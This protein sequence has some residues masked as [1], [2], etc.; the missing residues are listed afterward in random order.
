[1]RAIIHYFYHE[2]IIKIRWRFVFSLPAMRRILPG[3]LD[4]PMK[5]LKE[6]FPKPS[7]IRHFISE[8][9]LSLVSPPGIGNTPVADTSTRQGADSPY[10]F[11]LPLPDTSLLPDIILDE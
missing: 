11:E 2:T 3:I 7:D 8:D 6:I 5:K 1:M 9:L 10:M 4:N